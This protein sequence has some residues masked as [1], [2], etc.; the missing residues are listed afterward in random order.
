[1]LLLSG[2]SSVPALST[3]VVDALARA[4]LASAASISASAPATAQIAG[5][6]PS[7]YILSYC[8]KSLPSSGPEP[9]IGWL[10][11]ACALVSATGGPQA[12]VGL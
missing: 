9:V 3:A 4:C 12:A 6:P 2:A 10:R 7:Q 1:M 11:S 8:G 5:C